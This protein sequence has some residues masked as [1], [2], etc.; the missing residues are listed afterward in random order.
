MDLCRNKPG[1]HESTGIEEGR[2]YS[3]KVPR[4]YFSFQVVQL[5]WDGV[6][7][8]LCIVVIDP[9]LCNHH[10]FPIEETENRLQPV[11]HLLGHNIMFTVLQ[12]GAKWLCLQHQQNSSSGLVISVWSSKKSMQPHLASELSFPL[13]Y[14]K[15]GLKLW[16]W[17]QDNE[18][19]ENLSFVFSFVCPKQ[20]ERE[21]P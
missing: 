16:L 8:S 10:A 4:A 9:S 12:L 6:K 13:G 3:G 7:H 15:M 18:K 1:I 21:I 11:I 17:R 19:E 20:A 5:C 14:H 2:K